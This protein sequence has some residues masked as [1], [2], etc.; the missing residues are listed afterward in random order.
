MKDHCFLIRN[1]ILVSS[2]WITYS[3]MRQQVW[4]R[5][6][7]H[8]WCLEIHHNKSKREWNNITFPSLF[9][10]NKLH[11]QYRFVKFHQRQWNLLSHIYL[12][13]GIEANFWC[14]TIALRDMRNCTVLLH[15]L[16]S[17]LGLNS[18]KKA[19]VCVYIKYILCVCVRLALVTCGLIVLMKRISLISLQATVQTSLCQ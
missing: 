6:G 3:G 18:K 13:E 17:E 9:Q 5:D 2:P 14:S 12:Q 4:Q 8:F 10:K 19:T 1:V 15:F 16:F 11:C 7:L